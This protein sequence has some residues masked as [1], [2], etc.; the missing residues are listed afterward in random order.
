[1]HYMGRNSNSQYKDTE[2]IM[3]KTPEKIIWRQQEK[4][5]QMYVNFVQNRVIL[6]SNSSC[7]EYTDVCLRAVKE[8][9]YRKY[10]SYNTVSQLSTMDIFIIYKVLQ[11]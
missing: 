3:V 2:H 6:L 8:L 10:H 4:F 1:M 11:L 7:E 9:A 5:Q